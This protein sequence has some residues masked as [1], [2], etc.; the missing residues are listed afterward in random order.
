LTERL[1]GR[2]HLAD[3]CTDERVSQKLFSEKINVKILTGF[4]WL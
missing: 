2:S 4:N 1:K 3:L